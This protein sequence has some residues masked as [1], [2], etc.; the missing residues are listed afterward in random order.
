MKLN[1]ST[2]PGYKRIE[3]ITIPPYSEFVS[4]NG[5][6][7]LVLD[8]GTQDIFKVDLIFKGGRILESKKMTAKMA[9]ALIREGTS[10]LSSIQIAEQI[11][12]YGAVLRSG[13][14]L[15]YN[16]I[17]LTGLSKY[18]K[19]TI[20]IVFDILKN[21]IFP[22]DEID[23]YKKSSIAKLHLDLARNE[24]NC[25]R[26]FT[27]NIFGKDSPYGYNSEEECIN[28]VTKNDIL[29]YYDNAYGT[30]NFSVI[31]AGKLNQELIHHLSSHIEQ[32]DNTGIP[33]H[34]QGSTDFKPL[35]FIK[36]SSKNEHQAS[37]IIGRRLFNRHHQDF[38]GVNV[39]NTILGGYFGSRLMTEIR[40]NLGLTY[41]ISSVVDTQ[42]YDGYMYIETDVT[43]KNVSKTIEQIHL[44]LERLQTDIVDFNE[45]NMVKNYLLGNALNY[46]DGP[47][48]T[49]SFLKSMILDN[50]HPN[51]F[52]EFIDG[53][54]NITPEEIQDLAKKYFKKDD[55]VQVVVGR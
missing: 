2:G 5:V 10:N 39:L 46:F 36:Q 28:S 41:N 18:A 6:K 3:H 24:L 20:D 43:N 17:T 52:Y 32:V 22:A 4:A 30:S 27:E 34:Y 44:Q 14:H 29:S 7:I 9:A 38:T 45:L 31:A 1:W 51:Q 19:P 13:S 42:I 37:V 50:S 15:D 35:P 48:N 23:K 8:Q 54:K 12:Y 47:L 21:P 25:Y 11:D 53:V 55:L 33:L 40:E 26:L 16:Y 49:A